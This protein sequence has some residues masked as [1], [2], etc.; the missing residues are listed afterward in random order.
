MSLPWSRRPLSLK[1]SITLWFAALFFVLYAAASLAILGLSLR[2]QWEELGL[3]L[4]SQAENLAGYYSATGKVDYPEL[5]EDEYAAHEVGPPRVWLRLV[6]DGEVLAATPGM[7]ELPLP[8]RMRSGDFVRHDTDESTFAIA[9]HEVWDEP[10]VFVEAV[11]PRVIFDHRVRR[12][13]LGLSLV[14]LLLLPL[15][16]GAGRFLA[17]RALAPVGRVVEEMRSIDS[18]NLEQRLDPRGAPRDIG[19]LV[20]EFN[21]LLRRLEA[22]V[23]RMRRFTAD[24]SHELRTPVSILKTGL[25]VMLK[26][27]RSAEEYRQVLEENLVEIERVQRVVEGLLALARDPEGKETPPEEP[28]DLSQV[29]F[30]ALHSVAGVAQERRVRLVGQVTPGV[31][32]TGDADRLRLMVV[33]LLDNA[34]KYTPAR[35]RVEVRVVCDGGTTRLIVADQGQGIPPEERPRVFERFYRGTPAAAGAKVGGIG[36]SVALWVAET[37]GGSL[38]ILDEPGWGAVFEV[39]L[40]CVDVLTPARPESPPAPAVAG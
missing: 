23:E 38:T 35:K 29:V 4:F 3:Y 1:S 13:L 11:A 20:S 12:L 10:G 39:T 18:A 25:E 34:I 26:R 40:P 9:R 32:V 33:N 15:V 7:P 14:G 5:A 6:R 28:V 19:E 36:L 2:S 37:H 31:F 24:A 8:Q 21:A 27:P 17:A 22:S 16:A 30:D